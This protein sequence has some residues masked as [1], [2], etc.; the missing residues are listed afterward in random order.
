[1]FNPTQSQ[2]REFFCATW[3]KHQTH[4]VMTPLEIIAADWINFHPEYHEQLAD[5][6]GSLNAQ[7]PVEAGNSNPFLH[8]SMHLTIAEQI[9]ID[10][11]TGIKLINDQL[12]AQYGNAHD[13]AH[14]IMECLG[15]MIWQSQRTGSPPDGQAYLDNLK[16]QISR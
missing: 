7:Y 2:V 15:Q 1:M 6:Q 13:A 16:R 10:Q 9:S 11:P 8:L 12:C 14:A 3:Q 4:S 5:L